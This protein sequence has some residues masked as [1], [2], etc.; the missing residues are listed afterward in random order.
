MEFN[1]KNNYEKAGKIT[2]FLLMFAIFTIL[3]YFI[4]NFLNK[5][6]EYWSLIHMFPITLLIVLLGTLIKLLLK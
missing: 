6:P 3:L 1:K 2:G 5:I 4:L